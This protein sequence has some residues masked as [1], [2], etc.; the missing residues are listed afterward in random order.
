[1][2][3]IAERQAITG[4][5]RQ[6]FFAA[7]DGIK[8]GYEKGRV[9]QALLK[10]TDLPSEVVVDAIDAA[11]TIGGY[12]AGQVLQTAART[13]SISGAARDAYVRAADGLGEYEQ[14]QALAA[15]VRNERRK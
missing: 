13:Q 12:E 3:L 14:G 11:A 8:S 15:L 6:A 1:L 7:V 9:L 10:R 2:T 5:I 4:S